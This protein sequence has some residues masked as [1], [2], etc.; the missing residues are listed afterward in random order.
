MYTWKCH[1][2]IP[3]VAI[4]NKQ[5]K[6]VIFFVLQNQ[7]TGDHNRSCLG[8]LVPVRGGIGRETV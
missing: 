1:K 5:T 6:N 2:E 3:C 8:D 4:L 7:R